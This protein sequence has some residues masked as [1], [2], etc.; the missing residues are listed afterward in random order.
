M[1][2]QHGSAGPTPIVTG[3][4]RPLRLPLLSVSITK[5]PPRP[6]RPGSDRPVGTGITRAVCCHNDEECLGDS[7][8]RVDHVIRFIA[9]GNNVTALYSI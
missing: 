3:D 8:R 4:A 9:L 6:S 5:T 7:M 1:W 2:V